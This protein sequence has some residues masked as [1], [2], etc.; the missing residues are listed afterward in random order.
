MDVHSVRWRLELLY[1]RY[2]KRHSKVFLIAFVLL[3]ISYGLLSMVSFNST[4]A[5]HP[6]DEV[7]TPKTPSKPN[8][9]IHQLND[10][11]DQENDPNRSLPPDEPIGV[12]LQDDK[13]DEISN[14]AFIDTKNKMANDQ[15]NEKDAKIHDQQGAQQ[16]DGNNDV[17]GIREQ[18]KQYKQRTDADN[19]Q[20]VDNGPEIPIILFT[21]NRPKHLRQTMESILRYRPKSGFPIHISQDGDDRDVREVIHQ[22]MAQDKEKSIDFYEY[23]WHGEPDAR[24]RTAYLKIAGNYGYAIGRTF[25]ANPEIP[26]VILLE[27]DM[28][29]APD[30]FD[31][32]RNVL[33]L[34]DSDPTLY[35]ASAWNDNGQSNMVYDPTALYRTDCFPGLG[36]MMTRRLWNEMKSKWPLGFWDD[37]LREPPQRLGR[38]CIYPEIN[39]VYTFGEEGTSQGQFYAD[40][41]KN[42]KLNTER[43]DWDSMD[44]TYLTQ[45]AYDRFVQ[46]MIEDATLHQNALAVHNEI[47]RLYK[48]EDVSSL[49]SKRIFK[50]TYP[51]GDIGRLNTLIRDLRS[52]RVD[53]TNLRL[54]DD[55]KAGVPRTS[56]KGMLM[57]RYRYVRVLIVPEIL[58]N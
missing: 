28:E 18:K 2:L 13:F 31:Y 51:T 55:H 8:K 16:S 35:C 42:I 19:T 45:P 17:D 38:S 49:I 27:D 33:P 44:L 22:F 3:C 40:F 39:R 14:E 58:N 57:Y 24:F 30:F 54:I 7:F 47:D 26:A 46:K 10:I 23:R 9:P 5:S 12:D 4:T 43:V 52:F 20:D 41:L 1:R 11:I 36:W 37:W 29:I 32:F 48:E 21:Y 50:Y 34:F 6:I 15:E 25:D 56:Y 53:G